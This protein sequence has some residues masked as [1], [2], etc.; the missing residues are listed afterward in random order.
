MSRTF[1]TYTLIISALLTNAGCSSSDS[2]VSTIRLAH[3]LNT[4]HPVHLGMEKMAELVDEYSNGS[5]NIKI[6][7]NQQLGSEREALELLQIG[8]IG[9]TKVSS[10][11]IEN[12]VPRL[13]IY[14]V[15]YLFGDE[16]H[17]LRVLNGEIGRELL[18]EGEEYWLRGLTYYDA[19]KRS[20]YTKE[21]PVLTPDD[22]QG[23]KIRVMESQM[24][25]SMVRQMDGSP[26]PI[27]WGE[28]YTALQQGVVDGAENNPPSYVTSRHY[29]VA[30]YYSL[31]EHTMLPD[32]LI[33]STLLWDKLTPVQQGWVQR[34]A[35]SSAVYQRKI[36]KL[37]EQQALE[38]VKE[39]GVEV[40]FPDK[41]P[42]IEATRPLY[43]QYKDQEPE[44]YELI[45]RI[46]D[47]KEHSNEEN[48]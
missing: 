8:S 48:G 32:M 6:F 14:G 28:L 40:I 39:A 27:S 42:F 11:A 9:M 26:T 1:I 35:D 30:K 34:A 18:L 10:S 2:E 19:G 12:F 47:E 24:S 5:L 46:L 33:I 4:S 45:Q 23:L 21:R 29:E 15:P 31:D 36:W 38:Q 44:L 20:F 25:M 7:P 17:I 43:D 3:A 16:D 13:R 22:L 37:A 41:T